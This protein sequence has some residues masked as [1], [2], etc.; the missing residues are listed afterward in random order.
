MLTSGSVETFISEQM[1]KYGM[2]AL[3]L[4][5]LCQL[6]GI[7]ASQTR[8]SA[9]LRGSKVLP[10]EVGLQV[11]ALVEEIE[12]YVDSLKTPVAL[13]D[14]RQIKIIL[15]QRRTIKNGLNEEGTQIKQLL[16]LNDGAAE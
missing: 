8:L 7:P 5:E 9:A 13:T 10:N 11:R 14:A 4:G 2:A 12:D 6:Y 1:E 15:D 16:G 3:F